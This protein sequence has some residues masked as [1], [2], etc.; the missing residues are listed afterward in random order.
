MS[1]IEDP[2]GKGRPVYS[3]VEG[4]LGQTWAKLYVPSPTG[5]YEW[6]EDYTSVEDLTADHPNAVRGVTRRLSQ[7]KKRHPDV[8]YCP[9]R[10][11]PYCRTHLPDQATIAREQT[12]NAKRTTDIAL[13][14]CPVCLKA[15]QRVL[16]AKS[17]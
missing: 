12:L 2:K 9:A 15:A 4:P 5:E 1:I 17:P 6:V 11:G 13:V 14:T 10:S 8:H 16:A 3:L 7:N